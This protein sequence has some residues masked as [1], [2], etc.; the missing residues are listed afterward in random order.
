MN[1]TWTGHYRPITIGPIIKPWTHLIS[2]NSLSVM[3]LRPKDQWR[4]SYSFRYIEKIAHTH[5]QKAPL[6]W[7][8]WAKSHAEAA[9]GDL[10]VAKSAFVITQISYYRSVPLAIHSKRELA[11]YVWMW[12]IWAL[13]HGTVYFLLMFLIITHISY[14]ISVLI[15]FDKWGL[16]VYVGVWSMGTYILYWFSSSQQ[17][18]KLVQQYNLSRWTTWILWK[19]PIKTL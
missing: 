7:N 8:N 13:N 10:L 9:E 19:F 3:S 15:E 18:L 5:A 16:A 1:R 14:Y 12:S 17:K 6:E 11:V 4:L 2:P